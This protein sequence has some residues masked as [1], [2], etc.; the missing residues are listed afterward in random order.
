[1]LLPLRF[2]VDAT[3]LAAQLRSISADINLLKGTA[4]ATQAQLAATLQTLTEQANHIRDEVIA[5]IAA[6]EAA[7]GQTTPEV[8][9]ALE[10]LR[11]AVQGADDVIPG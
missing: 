6:L 1:M 10:A 11:S 5:K 4:M 9:A 7:I 8:E 2:G 3:E